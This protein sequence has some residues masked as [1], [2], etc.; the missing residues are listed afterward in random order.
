MA[1]LPSRRRK[2]GRGMKR[3]ETPRAD[4]NYINSADCIAGSGLGAPGMERNISYS[5]IWGAASVDA[6]ENI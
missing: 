5:S 2:E 4:I 6:E 1:M 3:Y